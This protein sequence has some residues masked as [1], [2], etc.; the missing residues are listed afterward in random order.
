M[1]YSK[2][3]ITKTYKKVTQDTTNSIE[4]EAK[5]IATKLHLDDRIN[6]TAKREAFIT[7]KD[8]KPNFVK[9]PTCRLINPAKAEV[10]KISKQLLDRINLELNE[11]KN[12]KA[13][14][15]W[16]NNIQHKD[17]YSFIAFN[18]MEF[19]P[20]I[21]I[22]LLSE[23]LQFASEYDTITNNERHITLQAKSSLLH[24]YGEP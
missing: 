4:Q 3:N 23:A 11:W 14:L 6:I 5:A 20:S 10:G 8:H 17:M 1:I 19:Y 18:V 21:S 15:S 22:E 12:T 13:A 9:N 24:S 16:F 2:K 7:F